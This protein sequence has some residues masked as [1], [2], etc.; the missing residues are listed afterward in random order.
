MR[1]LL[2]S[3]PQDEGMW[4]RQL[5]LLQAEG[6]AVEAPRLYGRGASIDGWAAQLLRESD[7]PFVAVGASMGE[8]RA[9]ALARREPERSWA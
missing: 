3:W 2:H 7:G 1:V 8:H 5:A 9:L 6:F 4:N